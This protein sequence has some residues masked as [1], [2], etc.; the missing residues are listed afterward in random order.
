MLEELPV[1]SINRIEFFQVLRGLRNTKPSNH[2]FNWILDHL[3]SLY[4]DM[5]DLERN[6]VVAFFAT[7]GLKVEDVLT[8]LAE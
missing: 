3:E 1:G 8:M 5:S 7:H 6:V 2:L 4:A